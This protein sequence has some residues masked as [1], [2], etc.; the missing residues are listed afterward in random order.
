MVAYLKARDISSFNAKAP[1]PKTEAFWAIVNSSRA[2]EEGELADVLDKLNNP[3]A[4][5]IEW[6]TESAE[7]GSEFYDWIN[8][9]KNRRAIPHRLETCG[10]VSV[11]NTNQKQGMWIIGGKKI[12]DL[13]QEYNVDQGSEPCRYSLYER[14]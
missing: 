11:R 4:V 12:C 8:D 6:L 14:G 2:P 3:N 7:E 10:Y 9:R 13:R 5:T 1:P